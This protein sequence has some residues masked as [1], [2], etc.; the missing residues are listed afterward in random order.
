MRKPMIIHEGDAALN[1]FTKALKTIFSIPRNDAER[2]RM[3]ARTPMAR[4]VSPDQSAPDTSTA[5]PPPDEELE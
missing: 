1:R 3:E 4:R 5:S 2:I